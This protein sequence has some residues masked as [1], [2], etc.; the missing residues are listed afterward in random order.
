MSRPS[1]LLLLVFCIAPAPVARAAEPDAAKIAFFEKHVR[2]ALVEHCIECHSEDEPESKLRLDTLA[3]MVRGGLRGPAIIPGKPEQSLLIRAVRHGELFKMPPKR[4]LPQAEIAALAKWVADGAVWPNAKPVDPKETKGENSEYTLT[5]EQKAFWSFQPIRRPE[6][7]SVKNSDWIQS[8]ID[9]FILARLEKAGINPAP[10]TDKATLLRRTTFALTGLP[11]TPEQ[12]ELFMNDKSPDAHARMIDQL[13]H[14]PHYGIRWGR[15]WLDVVRYADS[16]GM[17]ENLAHANAYRYRDYVVSAFNQDRPFDRF[18]REQI[19]GDLLKPLSGSKYEFDHLIA[20][21]FLS[22]GPKMLAEDDPVKMQMDI[23]DEQLD[24]IG[25]AFMGLTI[26]CARCHDHKFDPIPTADYYSLAGIFKSTHTMDNHNVVARWFERPISDEATVAKLA[27]I[28]KQLEA[29]KSQSTSVRTMAFESLRSTAIE[30]FGEYL[31]AAESKRQ[32]AKLRT[33][34]QSIGKQYSPEKF[35]GTLYLEAEKFQRG[36]PTVYTKGYG[37]GIGVI[38]NAGPTPNFV[39]YDIEILADGMYQFE[40]RYAAA[41]ARPCVLSINGNVLEKDFAGNVTG[42]WYPDKQKWEVAGFHKLKKGKIVLR[43]E[44][45]MYFPHIDKICIAPTNVVGRVDLKPLKSDFKPVSEFVTSLAIQLDKIDTKHP[46]HFWLKAVADAKDTEALRTLAANVFKQ[47]A[48][49]GLADF[50]KASGS[51][52]QLSDPLEAHFEK[53][54]VTRL[55]QLR[56]EVKKLEASKPKVPHA[57]GVR[58]GMAADIRIHFRG[59]HLTQGDLVPRRVPRAIPISNAAAIPKGE[60]GRLQFAKWLSS[61]KHPLTSRVFV[62]RVWRWHFG[63]GLVRSTDNFGRLGDRPTHPQ[64][65]DWLAAEFVESGWSVKH[66]HRLILQSA[67]YQQS[68]VVPVEQLDKQ[69]AADPEN[70]LW[71]RMSRRRLEAEAIRDSILSVSGKLNA[72]MKGSI[73]PSKN[74]AYVTSTANVNPNVYVTD[75]RSIYLPV[76]R[77]AIYEVLQAFDFADP[78]VINGSRQTTTV[79]PQALFMMNSA[80]VADKTKAWAEQLTAEFDN[81]RDQIRHM[82]RLAFSRNP[83]DTEVARAVA[84]VDFYQRRLVAGGKPEDASSRL[85]A[86]QALCRVVM[87]ANEFAYVE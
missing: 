75:R 14:S 21:G 69:I 20:T 82:Y 68:T 30:N 49:K 42:S 25:R 80:F 8:P 57:M 22:I 73:L 34:A 29:Q 79:A 9:A 6:L 56:E 23:I 77:S 71:A 5:D 38:L 76:V 83:N 63:A 32:K 17:D 53:E 1:T 48:A 61:D 67:T 87:A 33:T 16:N 18:V 44:Q 59:N 36:N 70:L 27:A 15:H 50:L 10:R 28:E 51:P 3:G 12:L 37:E 60:S 64:L 54:S 31:L 58:E 78:S 2:P 52:F 19:A 35:P 45:P 11:P 40:V 81:D 47:P 66:L 65:L 86:W 4:K 55:T 7:P 46:L 72:T 43:I 39:E 24:T 62:N 84:F 26:G 41:A 13:M 85:S 74:R